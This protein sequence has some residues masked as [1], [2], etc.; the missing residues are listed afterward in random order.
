M[1]GMQEMMKAMMGGSVSDEDMAEMQS[2]CPYVR[3]GSLKSDQ[4]NFTCILRNDGRY[5]WNGWRRNARYRQDDAGHGRIPR[6]RWT[7]RRR[8]RTINNALHS[9]YTRILTMIY[10]I[11]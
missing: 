1:G 5:A 9:M 10:L 8:G 6:V 3:F 2:M 4:R 7:W 11:H